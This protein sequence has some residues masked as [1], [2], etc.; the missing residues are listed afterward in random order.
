MDEKRR[1]F[2]AGMAAIAGAAALDGF[3]LLRASSAIQ[4]TQESPVTRPSRDIKDYP[5]ITDVIPSRDM[6]RYFPMIVDACSDPKTDYLSKIPFLIELEVSKIWMESLFEWDALS[7]SG[8]AGLQ[9]LMER[10]ARD[11]DLTVARSPEIGTLNSAISG[12]KKLRGDIVSKRQELHALV[13]T[14][15]GKLTP[16]TLSKVNKLRADLGST[17]T[18]RTA[19][20]RKLKAEKGKYV[21]KIHSLN[22]EQ[23][24]KYDA[25]FVP[26]LLIPKGIKHIVRD[27]M[28]C[29]NFFGGPVE[30]NAWRGVAAYNS[31]LERTKKWGGLPFIEETVHFTRNVI[32]HLTRTLELKY[33]YSTKDEKLIAETKRRLIL[34]KAYSVYVVKRGDCFDEIVREQIMDRHKLP[35]NK[36][37]NYIKDGKG[38]KVDPKKMSIIVPNQTFR[39]YKP[40]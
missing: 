8:A 23:R 22:V 38:N 17:Y 12:Y 7:N 32:S 21:A 11:F 6:K 5:H 29:K 34:K 18:K 31:G 36:A 2:I 19:A 9:Q 3:G 13:E 25:R 33:A 1:Q 20:Y 37:L 28:E 26:E 35:Y 4:D 10:T 24:K 30:M 15:S 40:G 27:I 14:G 39:I 16:A